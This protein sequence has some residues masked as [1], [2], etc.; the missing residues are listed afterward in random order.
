MFKLNDHIFQRDPDNLFVEDRPMFKLIR[1][2]QQQVLH[3][4]EGGI[5]RIHYGWWTNSR[6][7]YERGYGR[8]AGE[9]QKVRWSWLK[10][11]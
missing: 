2:E 5:N 3:R 10:S 8:K 9:N 4:S 11:K 7:S 1:K 6:S